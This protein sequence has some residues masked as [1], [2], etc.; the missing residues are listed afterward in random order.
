MRE[1]RGT[2]ESQGLRPALDVVFEFFRS[3][4]ASLEADAAAVVKRAGC[5]APYRH[6]DQQLMPE[7]VRPDVAKARIDLS[8]TYT[9]R[10]VEQ[11]TQKMGMQ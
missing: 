10:F 9:N 1:P 11:S 5:W 7:S 2:D 3:R 8:R 4:D 6:K